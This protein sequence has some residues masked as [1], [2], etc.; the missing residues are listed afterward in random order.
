MH[1]LSE[2]ILWRSQFSNFLI[3]VYAGSLTSNAIPNQKEQVH[4][5]ILRSEEAKSEGEAA[6]NHSKEDDNEESITK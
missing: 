5:I 2:N 6:K 1:H 4:A 3:K